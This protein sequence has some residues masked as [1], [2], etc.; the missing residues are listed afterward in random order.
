MRLA[1]A[2]GVIEGPV[3]AEKGNSQIKSLEVGEVEWGARGDLDMLRANGAHPD[4]PDGDVRG[5]YQ[6]HLRGAVPAVA[7]GVQEASSGVVKDD[8]DGG[9]VQLQVEQ[10][11]V[12]LHLLYQ[13][14]KVYH[15]YLKTSSRKL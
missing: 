2:R 13:A 1:D 6:L 8:V 12:P 3:L 4:V 11:V 7:L 10:R 9:P 15:L 14:Q 5:L